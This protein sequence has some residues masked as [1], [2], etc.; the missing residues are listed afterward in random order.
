[1]FLFRKVCHEVRTVQINTLTTELKLSEASKCV[2]MCV[3][4]LKKRER[5]KRSDYLRSKSVCLA[6]NLGFHSSM[7]HICIKKNPSDLL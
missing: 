4:A 7:S 5:G 6:P 1:M 2:C 3:G